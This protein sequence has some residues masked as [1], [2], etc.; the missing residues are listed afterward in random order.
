MRL[1]GAALILLFLA[2][3]HV[4][5]AGK[6]GLFLDFAQRQFTFLG[7]T[8]HPTDNLIR[9][10]DLDKLPTEGLEQLRDR[11][12]VP[13]SV[14]TSKP[15][16]MRSAVVAGAGMLNDVSALRAP[17]AIEVA[18]ALGVPV[19]LMHMQGEPRSMQTAPQYNDVVADIISYLGSRI[20][21]CVAAG[22]AR[23]CVLIDP[24][25]GFGKTLE[26]NLTLLR[27][28]KEF[29]A[30]GLPMLVGVSRK[31]MLGTITG[32]PVGELLASSVAAA[33]MAVERGAR[34][35]RVHDVAATVDALRVW[36][37]V[38]ES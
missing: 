28:L 2:L 1:T 27:R 25:F 8:F 33:V 23:E 7:I 22:I 37:A 32:R 24:G 19:C 38:V 20:D 6:P 18:A 10:A 26:H 17:G 3:P 14:D 5:V 35:V 21:A 34:I 13:I 29:S 36:Q 12:A 15:E 9:L 31:S 11:V 4:R 30:L 16:V